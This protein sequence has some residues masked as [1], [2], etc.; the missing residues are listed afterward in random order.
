MSFLYSGSLW[1]SI[2][3]GISLLCV[4]LYRWLV[5][6][7]WLGK[8]VSVFWWVELYFF[9]LECN[10]MSS[11]ELWDVYS[12]G[13][14]LG[15]LYLEA[16][17]CVPLLLENLLGMSCPGTYWPLCGAWFQCRY[18]GIWW[19]PVNECSLESGVPWSQGLDL[20]LLLLIIGLIFTVVSKLL[21]LYST[22]DKTSTLKMISFSTVRVTQ[23]GSQG[24]MEKRRGRRELEVTWMRWG[25]IHRGESRL[26]SNHFRMCTPQ[27]D[28]S[29]MF[30]ELYKKRWGR[31]ETEVARRIKGGNEKEGDRSSQ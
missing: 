13:V 7:S 28:C 18:G 24:Y 22:I 25:G 27:L 11:N 4:D 23:R 26:A 3:C 21:L 12:F 8:L 9:S 31:K 30:T 1:S 20:S 5:K 15:S 6:V 29:E 17:G 10:E 16:Q 14:T 19:A 2:Y